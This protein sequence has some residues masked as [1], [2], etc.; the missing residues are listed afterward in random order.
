MTTA[1]APND[2]LSNFNPL[3]IIVAVP[4]LSY[5][6]YPALH[7]RNIKFGRIARITFGF[8]LAWISGIIGAIVQW[9]VY[10]TNPCGYYP[11]GCEDGNGVSTLSVWLQIPNVA[12]GA[13]SECF[14]NVTAYELAYARSSPNM[15]SLVMALFLLNQSLSAALGEILTPAIVDPHLIWVWGGPAIALFVQTIIFWFRYKH[16]DSDEFMLY[17]EEEKRK[18]DRPTDSKHEPAMTTIPEKETE[19]SKPEEKVPEEKVEDF[20]KEITTAG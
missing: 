2:L 4:I 18:L 12:L 9:R 16:M 11:T 6:I 15:K 1:G 10:K 7:R 3:T 13:L 5:V 20:G 14:C 17:E 19:E 8:T